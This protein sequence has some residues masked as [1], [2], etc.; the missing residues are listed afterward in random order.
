MMLC[1]K[2]KQFSLLIISL[3]VASILNGQAGKIYKY[4][5]N[6]NLQK[7]IVIPNN[8]SFV[9]NYSIS[10][11]NI[12]GV[13]NES[14][15]F[16][17]VT[18][19]GHN[20]SSETGKP[21]LPVLCRLISIPENSNFR[22]S[23]T[24]VLTEKVIPSKN[25]F[26][27]LLYPKQPGTT[28]NLQ[29]KKAVFVMD[30]TA[31]SKRGILN[32]DTV[33]I[34]YIGKVRDK[35]LAD[36]IINPVRY[37]PASN[38]MEVITSMRIEV[39]F[40]SGKGSIVSAA[41][42]SS[43][44][45]NQSIDNVLL[46]YNS[47]DLLTGYSDQP[48]KMIIV[49]D[50]AFKK[51]LQPYFKWK[52][53]KGFKLTT[54]YKGT[55]LST[56]AQLK[57]TISKIY[58][59]AT[60]VDPAPEYLLIIGDVNRIPVADG[61]TEVS[62]M[63][64]GEFTGN[65]DYIPDM[66]VGRLPVADTNQLK[67]VIGKIIQ[68]EK[69]QFADTNKFYKR[70]LVTAGNDGG[71]YPYMNGQVKYAVTN[72]LNPA[73]K[74]DGYSFYYPQASSAIDSIKKLIKK[75]LSFI[76]Y[77]GHGDVS[78]WISPALR[79]TDVPLLTNK[80][81]YPFV[82]SNACMTAMYNNS[83]SFGNTMIVTA[84]KGAVGYIGCSN[85]S[86][87]DED[88]FWA[89]GVGPVNG[90]PKYSETGLGALDRL[91]HTHG[92]SSSDWYLSMG[93]VNYAGNLAVSESTS[94]YKKYYWETYTLL[95]DPST[96][97]YI[98]TPDTLKISIPDTLP[99]GIKSLSLTIPPFA[100]MAVSHFD[101]LWDAS[102][103]SPSGSVVLN[104]PGLS[105]DSCLIV[106]TG[107]NKIPVIKTVRFAEIVNKEYINLTT[108]SINDVAANNNGVADFGESLFIKLII[109]N[110]GQAGAS[111]LYAK[112]STN[113]NLVTIN[114]DSE[115]IG[116][117]NGKSQINLPTCFGITIS[118]FVTDKDFITFNLKLAD[119]KAVKNYTIDIGVHAPVLELVNCLIDD[120][121]TGN[122]NMI[123]EP[124][125]T[126]NLIFKISNTGTSNIAGTL[127]I[128]NHPS[129]VT[130]NNPV[131]STGL[132][133]NGSSTLVPV[134][135]KLAS[136]IPR[137]GS[138]DIITLLDCSP[139]VKN[140]VF[141]IPI[142]KTLESFEYQK[143]TI[144]PWI[145]SGTYPWTIV[146]GQATEGQYSARSGVIPNLAASKLKM[147]VNVPVSDTIRFSVKVSSE[148]N[149]DF[150]TF[151]LNGSIMF[152]ISGEVD[153]T[154]KKFALKEGFNLL[155]WSYEKDYSE[156]KG[157][158]CA[159]LDNIIFPTVAFINKDLKT[160]KIVTPQIG[161]NYNQ[162]QISAEVVNLGTDTL[163]SFNLAYQVNSNTP[164]IQNF[165]KKINPADTQ[166]VSFNQT[167]NLFGNGTYIV[168][169]F[170]SNN[171]DLYLKN[172]TVQITL[173]NTGIFDI[174]GKTDYKIKI[175]PNPFRLAFRME[176][177]STINED[178]TIS[179]I[180]VSGKLVWEE[181]SSIVP[182]I[183]SVIV[184]PDGL[185]PGLYTL[186]I[187]GKSTLKAARIIKIE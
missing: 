56:Y 2:G 130:I 42:S 107:Q 75:G 94:I 158:D 186:R 30:K 102:Y 7:G 38:E 92:E 166:V 31:Y 182:G 98:G 65:G 71:Y 46:N 20:S 53:Q 16:Y 160:N 41:P 152:K 140:K 88:Y 28:K 37:N 139:Y 43:L 162:E 29:T 104:M 151:T 173:L 50:P 126:F 68:Y 170:G 163:K 13:T 165:V 132:F 111:G 167:A 148:L 85:N 112:L 63:Y 60:S 184:Y 77:T 180:E 10:E 73:N 54:I 36:L 74:I 121:V 114:N 76:N 174:S 8:E 187:T 58:N 49:T 131:V 81:M 155:E 171:S 141:T 113:S 138:F 5:F 55:N 67:N 125:E 86:Y 14:G 95:G 124:G 146:S 6:G 178:I 134:S 179:I 83:G 40:S 135:V 59:S 108:S 25:S 136:N 34:E 39:S 181:K 3:L 82:I 133:L 72:Y 35:Q 17:R 159:W 61:T 97:P 150:L 47:S 80:N 48:V 154:Q 137:G 144:F 116:T 118:N 51:N 172:D 169:V 143:M 23:I 44:L 32:S 62:D 153:W 161:K 99:N 79:S 33:K 19:P 149:Y 175:S 127:K 93:Q 115:W 84:N 70:A 145:N 156:S 128:L 66:Y 24:N 106:I 52:T 120:S 90:D 69:F 18:I 129:Q 1:G 176:F 117:L 21:E 119:S 183:N 11:L 57:D 147:T 110:L 64:Y 101:T 87:W 12:E 157:S 142:G 123:A 109:N 177:E 26:N 103:A 96:I 27:G 22:I 15:D 185:L 105:N 45:F 164:V 100:Y 9:V 4:H 91:F 89:V 168:K 78:G 122:S